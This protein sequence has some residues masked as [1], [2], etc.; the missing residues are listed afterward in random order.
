MLTNLTLQEGEQAHIH[1][2][3]LFS[4]HVLLGTPKPQVLPDQGGND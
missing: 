4:A 2:K 1:G 3:H